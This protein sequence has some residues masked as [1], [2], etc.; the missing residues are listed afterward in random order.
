[1]ERVGDRREK[2]GGR[3]TREGVNIKEG[4]KE[5]KEGKG[6]K[7]HQRERERERERCTRPRKSKK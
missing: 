3:K 1:V 4:E 5:E 7:K 2:R 6:I